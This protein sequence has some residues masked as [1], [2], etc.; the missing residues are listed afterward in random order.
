MP[1]GMICGEIIIAEATCSFTPADDQFEQAH[2]FC[3][4]AQE[5]MLDDFKTCYYIIK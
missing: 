2:N 5:L 3:F 1:V 4:M